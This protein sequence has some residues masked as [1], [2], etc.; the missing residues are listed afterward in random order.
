MPSKRLGLEFLH[1]LWPV[2]TQLLPFD[3]AIGL[4]T[5]LV[6]AKLV[7]INILLIGRIGAF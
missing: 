6:I 1:P 2:A 5:E 3:K 4:L 7:C